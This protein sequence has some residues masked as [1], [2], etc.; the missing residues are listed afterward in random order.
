MLDE[1][2]ITSLEDIPD[3]KMV[4]VTFAGNTINIKRVTN[5]NIRQNVQKL[6]ADEY[7]VIATG[8]IKA[9]KHTENRLQNVNSIR[10]TIS[11]LRDLINANVTEPKNLRWITLTY[12]ENMTDNKRLYEDSRKYHQRLNRYFVRNGIVVPEYIEVVEPQERGA[13]H[14]HELLIWNDEAPFIPTCDLEKV[15][16]HGFV[17]IKRLDDNCDNIGAYLTPYLTDLEIDPARRKTCDYSEE[18]IV[19][20]QVTENGKKTAKKFIKG[21]RLS[22]YPPGMNLYRHSK[23]VKKPDVMEMSCKEAKEKVSGATKTFEKSVMLIQDTFKSTVFNAYY[24]TK[25]K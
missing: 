10:K 22:L 20:R 16:G 18:N 4:T 9:V 2:V 19:E 7:L 15:W 21:G 17:K 5:K 13:W 24:N 1:E 14:I 6:S 3:D 8:E 11:Q 23:G 25:R 12:R